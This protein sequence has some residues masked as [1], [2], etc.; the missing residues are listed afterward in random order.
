[1]GPI[2]TKTVHILSRLFIV[3][4]VFL[5]L[6]TSAFAKEVIGWVEKVGVCQSNVILRA[7]IDKGAESS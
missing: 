5:M 4:G 2:N 1:M 6:S 3:P 7:E